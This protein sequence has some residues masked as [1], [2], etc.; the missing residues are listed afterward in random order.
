MSGFV[1]HHT[2][3]LAQAAGVPFPWQGGTVR[4]FHER[5]RSDRATPMDVPE[6][7]LADVP[8]GE[9]AARLHAGLARAAAVGLVEIT[10]M[11]MRDWWY[12][13]ALASFGDRPLPARLRIYL[14][15]GLAE[16]SGAAEVDARRADC[17]PWVRLE[18]IKFYADGWLV[19]RTC[20]MCQSF[21]DEDST[22]ILF[23]GAAALAKRIEPFAAAGWRIAT[24]A[25]GDRAVEAVLDGYELVWGG[26]RR[27]LAAAS[28]RIE[29]GSVLSAELGSRIADLGVAV[30]IQPSFAVTDAAE[31]PVALGAE[32]SALAYPWASLAALGTRMLA[33]TDY[34]IE[35][36]EPLVSL[37]RLVN[38]RSA[39]PGFQTDGAAPAHSRLAADL[40]LAISTDPRAGST[41]LSADPGQASAA[42][43]DSINVLGTEPAPFAS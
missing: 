3:L 9:R 32:R 2:H 37:A 38:G 41:L 19:P 17:G 15:S 35:V 42:E 20:A 31:V 12:L 40:A 39:R 23:T 18:G 26:D 30:C 5:V 7:G 6:H 16:R 13:D 33:G 25:I 28:P 24:H 1:D 8:S 29:H 22:G 10:E 14:A 36:M 4:A 11:G 43:L 34:P 21:D 27:A